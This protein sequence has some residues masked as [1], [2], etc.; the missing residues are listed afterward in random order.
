MKNDKIK[1][2]LK[3][4]YKTNIH[5]TKGSRLS[6]EHRQKISE[7][8]KGKTRSKEHCLNLKLALKGRTSPTKGRKMPEEQ[9]RKISETR[10]KR[11]LSGKLIHPM[12][13]RKHSAESKNKMSETQKL[14]I[15]E[16]APMFGR[17]FSDNACKA[18]SEAQKRLCAK[19]ERIQKMSE[20]GKRCWKNPEY[21]RKQMIA[22]N[23]ITINKKESLLLN[24]LNLLYPN[25][26][27]FVGCGELIING[28]C[29][30]FVNINGQKKIIE[31]FGDY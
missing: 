24:Q 14:F 26:W 1:D 30:D 10:K 9:K 23:R 12:L 7:A 13:G 19:P 17:K 8:L 2:A 28:K 20:I 31:L 27:R 3:R 6:E 11:F 18:N 29:P 4:F 22:R 21:V 16:K 15:G 5:H 25:E